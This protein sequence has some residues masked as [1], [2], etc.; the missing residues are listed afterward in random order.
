MVGVACVV[1]VVNRASV[2]VSCLISFD[3]SNWLED[4]DLGVRRRKHE[5]RS[6]NYIIMLQGWW[7]WL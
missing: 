5:A 2:V 7:V 3:L 1:G 6:Y 4:A